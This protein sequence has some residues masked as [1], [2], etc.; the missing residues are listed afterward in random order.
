MI[1]EPL[2]DNAV[3]HGLANT[4]TDGLVAIHVSK[5][6]EFIYINVSDNGCGMPSEEL[7]ALVMNY[8]TQNSQQNNIGLNNLKRRLSMYYSNRASITVNSVEDCGFEVLISI[9]IQ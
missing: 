8:F 6:K 9:P 7:E 3:K 1:I 5:S 2:I 4:E